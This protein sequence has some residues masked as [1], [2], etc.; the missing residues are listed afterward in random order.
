MLTGTD[1]Q[2]GGRAQVS[3]GNR[4]AC[5][6][7]IQKLCYFCFVLSHLNTFII[8]LIKR[9]VCPVFKQNLRILTKNIVITPYCHREQCTMLPQS[10]PALSHHHQVA[11]LATVGEKL[12]YYTLREV[13]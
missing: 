4:D 7:S 3:I 1:R 11:R 10:F 12:G 2:A 8:F 13:Y 9:K 6:L 5:A